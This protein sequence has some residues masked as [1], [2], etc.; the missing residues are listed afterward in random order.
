ME[1]RV[2]IMIWVFG[3]EGCMI[4]VGMVKWV[5]ELCDSERGEFVFGIVEFD[6][7]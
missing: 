5:R 7:G 2:E 4:E 1:E 6:L 3:N